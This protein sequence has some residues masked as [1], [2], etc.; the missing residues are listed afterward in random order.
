[1]R[2]Y[3]PLYFEVG[4]YTNRLDSFKTNEQV[5]RILLTMKFDFH[6]LQESK[7]KDAIKKR[8]DYS[9]VIAYDLLVDDLLKK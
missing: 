6:G 7:I 4:D 2:E 3:V 8:K 9:F 1:M 5:L